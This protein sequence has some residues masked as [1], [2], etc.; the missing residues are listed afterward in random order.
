MYTTWFIVPSLIFSSCPSTIK[1]TQQKSIHNKIENGNCRC[2]FFLNRVRSN[3][4]GRWILLWLLVLDQVGSSPIRFYVHEKKLPIEFT[5]LIFY[6][7]KNLFPRENEKKGFIYSKKYIA[8]FPALSIHCPAQSRNL[9]TEA[10]K[11]SRAKKWN[12]WLEQHLLQIN[13]SV[14]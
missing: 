4:S 7:D 6:P 2:Y 9:R 8:A 1:R 10:N 3:R 11:R 12:Q 13:K 5:N 14:E